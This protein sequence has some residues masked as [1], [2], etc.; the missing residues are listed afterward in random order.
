MFSKQSL[1]LLSNNLVIIS[2]LFKFHSSLLCLLLSFGSVNRKFLLPHFLD[3]FLEFEFLLSSSLKSK[4]FKSL[5]LSEFLH[6]LLS[7]LQFHSMLFFF[8]LLLIP[9]V[10][11]LSLKHH[12]LML[13][14]LLDLVLLFLT[15]IRIPFFKIQLQSKILKFFSIFLSCSFFCSESCENLFFCSLQFSFHSSMLLL[16][17]FNLLHVFNISLVLFFL[18]LLLSCDSLSFISQSLKHVLECLSFLHLVIFI[19]S[20][21]FIYYI[22]NDFVDLLFF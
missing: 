16:S 5:F 6:H 20:S 2:C 17:T 11:F 15:F 4:L 21:V 8:S 10:K 3:L 13:S 14:L 22:L 7:E 9:L 18:E 1:L 12:L 19:G